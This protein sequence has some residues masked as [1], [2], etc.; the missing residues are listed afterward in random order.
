M[1]LTTARSQLKGVSLTDAQE[2]RAE[3]LHREAIV[4]DGSLTL[5]Q[6]DRHFELARAGGITATNHTVIWPD[7]D[8]HQALKE[9]N[10]C[11]RW[12]DQHPNQVL[13]ATTVE[14]IHEAKR[15]GREAIIFGPQNTE[16]IGTDL[17][18][19]GTFYDLGVRILQLTYQRQNHVGAGC[20][21]PRDGGL[22]TFGRRMVKEMN[23]LGIVVDV[24]HGGR[25]TA[26]D[27]MEVSSTPVIISHSHPYTPSP[28]VRAKDDDSL[29]ALAAQGGVIG[30]TALSAFLYR[31]ERPRERPDLTA[32]VRHVQYLV[33]LIGV[34]HVGIALDFE[35]TNTPE[36]YAASRLA[37]P[38]L[39]TGWSWEDKRI[40]DLEEVDQ[41]PNVTR[42]LVAAGFSDTEIAKML[43]GNYLRVF[44]QVWG[45]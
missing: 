45:S 41:M 22:S 21:E 35:E 20:G 18:Y 36:H 17:D 15:T 10:S 3:R 14:H 4:V 1:A 5:K 31:P 11:R 19:L 38:E 29:R 7:R 27:A 12:I 2:E 16:M 37:N 34:D 24:S 44:E 30:L 28:H 43:G 40:W 25:Q 8:L 6:D 42:A 33:D 32:F 26:L 13:L 23:A 39:N 9:V